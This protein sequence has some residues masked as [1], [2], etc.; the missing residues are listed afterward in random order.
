[1]GNALI[2]KL[3]DGNYAYYLHLQKFSPQLE[4]I[5]EAIQ[6]K[7]GK[8]YYFSHELE[9][10]VR[11]Q[12]GELI[13]FSGESGA[14]FAH[15]HFELRDSQGNVLNP[16]NYLPLPQQD[17]IAPQFRKIV[18]FPRH[19]TRLNGLAAVL[20]L[21]ITRKNG[22]FSAE[23][24]SFDGPFEIA[25]QLFDISDGFHHIAPF[26]IE[27]KIDGKS[28]YRVNFADFNQVEKGQ[29][30]LLYNLKYSQ[31]GVYFYNLFWRP[32]FSLEQTHSDLATILNN[33]ANGLHQLE[34]I[35]TDY[36]GNS[37]YFR[38]PLKKENEFNRKKSVQNANYGRSWGNFLM[39]IND[40][41]VWLRSNQKT[42][43]SSFF[44]RERGGEFSR[45]LPIHQDNAGSY[46][47]FQLEEDGIKPEIAWQKKNNHLSEMEILRLP[48]IL[49]RPQKEY[50]LVPAE[51]VRVS[52]PAFNFYSPQII[53]VDTEGIDSVD[54][55]LE[56]S[57]RKLT[58]G[59]EEIVFQEGI[60]IEITPS[61]PI[62]APEKYAI[63]VRYKRNLR[64]IPLPTEF[65]VE[66]NTF[67]VKSYR[68]GEFLLL[69][70]RIAPQIR[71]L[72]PV[73]KNLR[74]LK[75]IFFRIFDAGRGLDLNTLRVMING[76]AQAHEDY[77]AD[78]KLL[79]I[80]DLSHFQPGKNLIQISI[81]DFAGNQSERNFELDL[82]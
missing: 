38:M 80:T 30:G 49:L 6:R 25:L 26:R 70:D 16:V 36:C 55:A 69:V 58:L 34:V 18:F 8:F 31:M 76:F 43:G 40:Q 64:W 78:R 39:L 23:E 19:L 12:K 48:L 4:A 28:F 41:T 51:G 60:K 81:C 82:K 1:V 10:P 79:S 22:I 71:F 66:K 20:E 68:C 63:Y 47:C 53:L 75:A 35:A 24:I 21:N 33:L 9:K 17:R 42:E 46:L 73:Q 37:S 59:P 44:L 65:N 74:N 61:R 77:D 7:T 13:A 3:D 54:T 14:G 15:L 11:V 67:Q 45:P 72:K 50:Q 27:A 57:S 32:G 29:F 56:V 62:S 5:S 52:I 2:L